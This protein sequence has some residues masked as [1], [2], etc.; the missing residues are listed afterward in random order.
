L[1]PGD[2]TEVLAFSQMNIV[3]S[4]PG[5][6]IVDETITTGKLNDLSV[7][8]GKLNDLS[9]TTGKLADSSVITAKLNDLS[10]TTG[11]LGDSSVT[12]AKIVDGTIVNADINASAA[13]AG[14]KIS[15]DFGSQNVVTT[16]TVAATSFSGSGSSL[17]GIQAF[18]SGTVMLFQQTTAPTG[19]TKLTTHDDKA[20]RI[21]SGTVGSGGATAFSAV[22]NGTVGATTLTTAQM[23]SHSH[24]PR[25]YTNGSAG[26]NNI[27]NSTASLTAENVSLSTTSTGGGGSHTHSMDVAYVDVIIATKD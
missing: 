4:I 10:V 6:N 1:S 12:S 23:P 2:F 24:T 11:K 3:D 7:T 13:I 14:T 8:T 22:L 18:D 21:V 26:D 17:T 27:G 16:G 19:W 9:V 5:D 25:R 15:P 20:L